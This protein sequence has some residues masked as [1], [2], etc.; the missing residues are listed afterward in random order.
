MTLESFATSSSAKRWVSVSDDELAPLLY[1]NMC[2]TIGDAYAA[3]GY[4][5]SIP[6]FSRL[7][8]LAIR[9][10]GSFAMYMAANRVK[11]TLLGRPVGC[12]GKYRCDLT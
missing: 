6:E 4:V 8:R 1:P 9:G 12:Y 11:S 2:R 5:Q 10:I 7:Q 3:F